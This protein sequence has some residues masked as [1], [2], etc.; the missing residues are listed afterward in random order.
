MSPLAAKTIPRP[1][2]L[3]NTTSDAQ[4]VFQVLQSGGIV[5]V[6]T[7]VGYGLM[8]SSVEAIEKAFTAK[9]RRPG[10][11][12][13]LIGSYELHQELHILEPE[14]FHMTR[15][16]TQDLDMGVGIVAPYN[17]DH[18]IMANFTPQT[19][20]NIVKNGKIGMFVGGGSLNREICRLN[21]EAGQ[22]MV[23]SSANLTGR[24]QKFRVED[25]EDE[26]KEVADLIVDYG[27][28]RYHVY[29][30]ASILVDFEEMKVLRM[31]SCYEL[32][33]ERMSRFWGVELPEDP[34][35]K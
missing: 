17:P 23:G 34:V 4:Q 31:G 29:G 19:L 8:A 21:Y 20:A 25:I 27:L 14:K 3:P 28:Q 32:F 13:G 5:I 22:V 35:Y 11:P 30:R 7:E 9:Q 2:H 12:H 26:I 10:H 6:P 15:V 18:P 1:G 33:R 24:G 16:L